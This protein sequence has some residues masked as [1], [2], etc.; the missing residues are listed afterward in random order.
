M[1]VESGVRMALNLYRRH[2]AECE[3]GHPEES[4]SGEFEERSKKWKRCGC[5][6]FAA[7]T[8][9]GQ[10]RRRQTG[11]TSWDHAKEVA[12]AWEAAGRWEGLELSHAQ[13]PVDAE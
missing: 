13:A 4:R 12:A 9:D 11:K 5:V 7:G 6:I 1:V 10:F 2:R 3:G 8:L